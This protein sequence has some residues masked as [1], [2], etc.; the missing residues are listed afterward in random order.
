MEPFRR[1]ELRV[2]PY[3]GIVLPVELKRLGAEIGIRTRDLRLT[4]ALHHQ[5]VLFRHGTVLGI[6]TPTPNLEGWFAAVDN[7][8]VWC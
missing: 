3:E 4:K 5:T 1:L 6:R 2:I 8:T 7:S